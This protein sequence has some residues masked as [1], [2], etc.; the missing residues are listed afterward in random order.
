[1]EF[2][3][4][5]R[6]IATV[7]LVVLDIIFMLVGRNLSKV[8]DDDMV[9]KMGRGMINGGKAFLVILVIIILYKYA[10]LSAEE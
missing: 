5:R 1:M 4:N 3:T 10:L 9:Q 8:E 7:I 6:L 2:L